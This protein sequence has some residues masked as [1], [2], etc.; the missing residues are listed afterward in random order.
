MDPDSQQALFTTAPEKELTPGP[1]EMA[2]LD[3]VAKLTAEG[4]MNAKYDAIGVALRQIATAVDKG[5]T[6]GR[7]GVS[8]ATA[9]LAKLL[10]ETLADLPEPIKGKDPFYDAIDAQVQALTKEALK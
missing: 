10:M 1:I 3:V 5:I 2:V 9:N 7:R 4:L 6:G 8:V